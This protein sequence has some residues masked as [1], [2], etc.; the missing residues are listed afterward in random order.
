MSLTGLAVLL[1]FAGGLGLALF[2]HPRYGLYTYMAVYYLDPPSRWWGASLPD[3]RWSLIAGVVALLATL[4]KPLPP[5]TPS[6]STTRP[7]RLLLA[8]TVWL[9]IQNLWALAPDE[10]LEASI[11]FTKYVILFV[12]LYRLVTSLE[13]LNGV[14][15]A[16]VL[17][18]FYLGWLAHVAPAGGRLEG[19]GGPGIDD[20]NAL[21]MFMATGIVC[22]SM[23]VLGEKGWKRWTAILAMPFLLNTIVQSQ[24][25][26]AMLA[27]VCAGLVLFYLKPKP[28]RRQFYV[29]AVLGMVLFGM[30]A[31]STFWDRMR[32]LEATVDDNEQIDSSAESRV[33]LAHAQLQMFLDHPLGVGHRGTAVLSP[34]YL[35]AK[36]LTKDPNDPTAAPARSSHNSF[37]SALVEQGIPGAVIFIWLAA[38]VLKSVFTLKRFLNVAAD[39]RSPILIYG[40]AVAGGAIVVLVAGMFTDY[41]KTEVQIWMWALL[42]AITAVHIPKA[43]TRAGAASRVQPLRR[44][45]PVDKR[46][47]RAGVS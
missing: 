42:A 39:E 1:G 46:K 23:V 2:R 9:W 35:D 40:P 4:R 21:A 32:T 20:S 14:L 18:C 44:P 27:L 41:L 11:L 29:F 26:G 34:R 31:Q 8:F 15:I 38:W 5:G 45:I 3:M 37:M 36:W 30:V 47:P 24:S 28:F 33:V 7:A 19:V 10:N 17:G 43:A 6:W 16:H 13:E 12:M 22:A 25:R